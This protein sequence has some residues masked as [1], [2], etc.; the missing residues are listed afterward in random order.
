MLAPVQGWVRV[1]LAARGPNLDVADMGGGQTDG[2]M[3]CERTGCRLRVR[4]ERA[5][6]LRSE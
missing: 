5:G 3:A 6:G 1:T 4:P 2:C